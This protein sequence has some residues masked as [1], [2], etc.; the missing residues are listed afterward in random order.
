MGGCLVCGL[1]GCRTAR[2]MGEA[3]RAGRLGQLLCGGWETN[4]AFQAG[5][6]H[7]WTG[8]PR[9]YSLATI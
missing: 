7:D 2:G 1:G 8:F 3:L 4:A 5:E 6:F 9:K